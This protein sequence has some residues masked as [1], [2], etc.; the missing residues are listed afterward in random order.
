MVAALGKRLAAE[1]ESLKTRGLPVETEL[2]EGVPTRT[3][4]ESASLRG[5]QLVALATHGM[6][7]VEHLV[8]GIVA[9]RIVQLAP[10]PVLTLRPRRGA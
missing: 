2:V 4:A 8:L 7:G 5:E 10:C 9:E 3:I 6:R 1:A